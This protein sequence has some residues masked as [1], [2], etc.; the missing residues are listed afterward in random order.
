MPRQA[1]Q[2]ELQTLQ[3]HLLLMGSMCDKAVGKAIDSLVQ[4]DFA[5]ARQVIDEDAVINRKRYQIEEQAINL[6]ARQQPMASDLRGIV[7]ILN[8]VVDLERIGD[9][10]AGIA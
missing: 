5:L 3:D 9:Y 1:Y 4:R 7:A 2:L 10:A 6:I 8:I